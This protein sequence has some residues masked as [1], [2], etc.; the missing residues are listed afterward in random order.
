MADNMQDA[1]KK[2]QSEFVEKAGAFEVQVQH[3]AVKKDS[4]TIY[5]A[6]TIVEKMK[7]FSAGVRFE[8]ERYQVTSIGQ[9]KAHKAYAI[10]MHDKSGDNSL[11]AINHITLSKK[12]PGEPYGTDIIVDVHGPVMDSSGRFW[13]Q[14][15]RLVEKFHSILK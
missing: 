15:S 10:L 7:N 6:S 5:N 2:A 1:L 3:Q 11:V 12:N 13:E 4:E 14:K 9:S 8:G